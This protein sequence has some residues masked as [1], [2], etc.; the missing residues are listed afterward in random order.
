[1]SI[2]LDESLLDDERR[3][4]EADRGGLLRSVATAGAQVRESL[5][6][7]AEAEVPAVLAG[8]RPRAVLVTA[9]PGAD[10]VAVMLAALADRPDSVAPMVRQDGPVLPVWA[11]PVDVLLAVSAS[12]TAAAPP[13]L[14]EAAAR[15]GLTVFGTG[16]A[17]SLLHEACGRNRAAYVPLP[18][19]RHP[20]A[21]LWA[22]LVPLLLAAG[23]LGVVP[24]PGPDL[25]GCADLLDA[26]AE[27]CRPGSE[28]YGN[29]AKSLALDLAESVPVV[30]GSTPPGG[31][32]AR[33]LAGL[34]AAAGRPAVWGTLP[35]GPQRL[36]GLVTAP[37]DA[38]PDDDLFRDRVDDPGLVR[39][40]LVLVRAGDEPEQVRAQVDELV[41]DCGRRGVP[42]TEVMAEDAAGPVGRLASV[43][44]LLDF[45]AAYVGI[46]SGTTEESP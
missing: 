46:A 3:L 45:T 33:R 32:A 19:G 35:V 34:L 27:R 42:V 1:M 30:I 9:D 10:D 18:G 11:G 39:S 41:A 14:V 7:A 44:A 43:V 25:R 8:L 12:A 5:A 29:P 37:A 23:E 26:L 21:G 28:T 13:S 6:L 31:A 17:D 4:A 40:R 2:A 36:A 16:P 24:N 15:R 38:G 22:P 20:R